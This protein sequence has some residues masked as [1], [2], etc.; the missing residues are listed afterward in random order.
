MKGLKTTLIIVISKGRL[1]DGI[2]REP[3][4]SSPPRP[5]PATDGSHFSNSV[6]RRCDRAGW[7]ASREAT[8]AGLTEN[9]MR[10]QDSDR[11]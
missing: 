7:P 4:M 11:T 5:D 8:P 1:R 9:G 6:A 3:S 10:L 2:Q